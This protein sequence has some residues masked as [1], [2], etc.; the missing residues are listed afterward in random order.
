MAAFCVDGMTRRQFLRVSALAAAAT[1]AGACVVEVPAAQP[2]QLPAA[3]PAAPA[4]P[5]A[6]PAAPASRFAEAPVLAELVAKGALPPVDERLPEN[7]DAVAPLES[8]GKYGGAWRR[9]FSGVSDRWGPT[10]LKAN[11]L[12]WYTPAI[13]LRAALVESWETSADASVWT[14]HLRKGMRW[15][16]GTPFTSAAFQWFY[17]YH[18]RN[19]EIQP[20]LPAELCTGTVKQLA[21]ITS[22]DDY[23][24]V[25]AFAHPNPLFGYTMAGHWFQPFSP[26]HYMQQFHIALTDDKDALAATV[27]EKGF[28][29]WAAYFLDRNSWYLNPE[30]PTTD[31]WMA[32]TALSEQLFVMQRNPYYWQVDT[33]GQQLPYLDT[34]THR[35][36]E[37]GDVFTMWILN[38]EIDCQGR[39][40]GMGNYT[41]YKENEVKG[42]FHVVF[43]IGAGHDMLQL[44]LTAK[45]P[46]LRAFFQDR[47][48]RIAMMYAMNREEMNDV[49][50]DGRGAVRQFSPVTMSPNYHE[51]LS[52]SYIAYDPAKA[53]AMLDEAG[54]A[55]KDADGMRLY[56]D[57]SKEPV[58]FIIE[59]TTPAGSTG[60]DAILMVISYLEAVGVKA[61]YRY[62]ERSLYETRSAAN[63]IE[64]AWWGGNRTILPIIDPGIILGT[65]GGFPWANAWGLWKNREDDPNGEK[66]PEGHWIWTIWETWNQVAA[67]PDEAKRNAL[68]SKIL[69]IWADECPV[70]GLLGEYP[71]PVIVKNR[72]HNYPGGYPDENALGGEHFQQGQFLYWEDPENHPA[73][74]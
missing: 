54:Y 7:P 16:D 71:A 48:V 49:L 42:D 22:P 66:P 69:D 1:V 67:E 58:S 9:G 13:V 41:L 28:D 35:L 19:A 33:D 34:V 63:E 46:R 47:Q 57:G 74:V 53:N 29:S 39:G 31:P 37:S 64:A 72:L 51:R 32:T 36:Y 2:A 30:R 17:D 59:G 8:I 12:L 55:E 5:A 40:V 52:T 18:V 25:V 61:S 4:A 3:A 68:F 11:N 23:T 56:P 20:I 38:G 60:E 73:V 15:S 44:N 21:T 10:K 43:N 65:M 62:S 24:V 26:H 27:K 6:A 14:F 45:E 70:I 50:Q